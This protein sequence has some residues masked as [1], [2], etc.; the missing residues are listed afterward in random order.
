M[1]GGYFDLAIAGGGTRGQDRSADGC[2]LDCIMGTHARRFAFLLAC[3]LA[4]SGSLCAQGLPKE[5]GP[6]RTVGMFNIYCLS[7]L[8]DLDGVRQAAGFG[9]FAQI[10]GDELEPYQ[11]AVPAEEL[12]AWRFHDLGAEYV[13]TAARSK[14]DESF[15]KEAPAFA[16]S[17]SVACSLL[18]PASD[19]G[20]A[21]L[22]QLVELLGRP[23]DETWDEGP[24]RVHAW[25]G[26]TSRLLSHVHYYAPP[27]DGPAA[28]LSATT[29]VKD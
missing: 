11:P 24:M 29:F 18:F 12:N 28:V 1:V 5:K 22:E 2:A 3:A 20:E 8:P 6:A 9:E 21:V 13:L 25:S 10:T 19:P 26:Q 23:A 16:K 15:K 14:P 17:T 27:K 4:L 7:Q